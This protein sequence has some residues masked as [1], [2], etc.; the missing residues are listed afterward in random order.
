MQWSPLFS[1]SDVLPEVLDLD[2]DLDFTM[3][4]RD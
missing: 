4:L 3:I 1:L 2:L